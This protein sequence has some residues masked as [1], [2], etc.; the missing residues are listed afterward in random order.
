MILEANLS[1]LNVLL[2]IIVLL[3]VAIL[4]EIN[5]LSKIPRVI[6]LDERITPSELNPE[7]DTLPGHLEDIST[8]LRLIRFRLDHIAKDYDPSDDEDKLEND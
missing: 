4:H 6:S 1:A 7:I 2:F 8:Q 3:L 5:N